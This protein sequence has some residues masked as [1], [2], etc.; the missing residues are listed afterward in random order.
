MK[1]NERL[2]RVLKMWGGLPA[3]RLA[4]HPASSFERQDA[5][6]TGRQDVCPTFSNRL[7]AARIRNSWPLAI[8]LVTRA[9]LVS[10]TLTVHAVEQVIVTD[11][12]PSR[13]MQFGYSVALTEVGGLPLAVIGAPENAFNTGIRAGMAFVVSIGGVTPLLPIGLEDGDRFGASVAVAVIDNQ[14]VVL[15][16]APNHH[17]GGV[18]SGAAYLFGLRPPFL[19]FEDLTMLVP[20]DP[21]DDDGF[22]TA[23]GLD[24]AFAVIGAPR[25]DGSGLNSG[26]V[27]VFARSADALDRWTEFRRLQ[28]PDG[29]PLDRFGQSLALKQGALLVGAP[30]EARLAS[31]AAYLFGSDSGGPGAWGLIQELTPTDEI[32][33]GLFGRDR[34]TDLEEYRGPR[35][36]GQSVDLDL[37]GRGFAIV[38]APWDS[39]NGLLAGAAYIFQRDRGGL[40]NWGQAVK[41]TASGDGDVG[42]EFGTS[43]AIA[44][45]FALVGSPH[46]DDLGAT[47]SSGSVYLFRRDQG[48]EDLWG[49]IGKILAVSGRA[50]DEFGRSCA[51]LGRA[52]VSPI[53][54]AGRP[55]ADLLTAG[56]E[57]TGAAHFLLGLDDTLLTLPANKDSFL[58]KHHP[59]LSEGAHPGLRIQ[60]EGRNRV[61]VGFDAD[62]M[63]AFLTPKGVPNPPRLVGASLVLTISEAPRH[64]SE[65]KSPGVHA[66]PVEVDFVE[67][68]GRD[69]ELRGSRQRRGR[70]LEL[71]GRHRDRQPS[72]RLSIRR[73]GGWVVWTA[74]RQW[75]HA[76]R[77]PMGRG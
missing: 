77:R 68:N 14:V 31:G 52:G 34:G 47:G 49:R 29:M 74:Y 32:R 25:H 45:D 35:H 17:V 53:G 16:G 8:S 20:D 30:S 58:R 63:A 60:K 13:G 56:W 69:A 61:I 6:R 40:D 21:A 76:L 24:E 48:G 62:D 73:L 71:S 28:A 2:E 23:V 15:V 18:K 55:L 22:G 36:F 26:R 3:C 27:H 11:P 64:W 1:A 38:G 37:T 42:D 66:H 54:L 44:G 50:G 39:G 65:R 9:V 67:G 12:I 72:H 43:V 70:H 7:L 41:L 4:R 5:A 59:D 19:G 46:D 10:L 33:G 57:D 75:G 51:L